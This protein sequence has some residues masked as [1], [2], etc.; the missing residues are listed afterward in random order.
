MAAKLDTKEILKL[1][2]IL[3]E[4]LT[5]IQEQVA[6]QFD[7]PEDAADEFDLSATGAA[8]AF[9]LLVSWIEQHRTDGD[10]PP[11]WLTN[12]Y[13][14]LKGTVPGPAA[15]AEHDVVVV[16][17]IGTH[18][19]MAVIVSRAESYEECQ[20]Q[21]CVRANAMYHAGRLHTADYV[22]AVAAIAA[23]DTGTRLDDGALAY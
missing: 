13:P 3:A 7:L 9:P 23:D 12:A 22:N 11:E 2:H 1:K 16:W 18:A 17:H 10:P 5:R 15:S 19:G 14:N 6:I 8:N 20:A 21:A 4:N